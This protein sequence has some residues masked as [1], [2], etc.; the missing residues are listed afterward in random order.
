MCTVC[1]KMRETRCFFNLR[2]RK[3]VKTYSIGKKYVYAIDVDLE[4]Q[5]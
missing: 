2:K 3:E 4:I 1:L 5:F